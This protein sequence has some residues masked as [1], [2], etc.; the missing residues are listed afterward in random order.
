MG[1]IFDIMYTIPQTVFNIIHQNHLFTWG[2]F[3]SFSNNLEY[4]EWKNT[5]SIDE[6]KRLYYALRYNKFEIL[7]FDWPLCQY[8]KKPLSIDQ[9]S[10]YIK[11]CSPKC[12]SNSDQRKE[13]FAKTCLQK[14]GVTNPSKLTSQRE[15]L[16]N[17]N[18]A[19]RDDVRQK[20]RERIAN[21]SEEDW[22]NILQKRRDTFLQKYGTLQVS[23]TD[24]FQEKS[25]KTCMERYGVEY[26]SQ[27]KEN[28][29]K[30]RALHYDS[31]V[32]TLAKRRISI[33]SSKEEY[34]NQKEVRYRCNVC[35]YEWS[36]NVTAP[37]RIRCIN[38]HG[39]IT[40]Y[41]EQD[42]IDLIKSMY[43]GP[44]YNNIR[45]LLE[46]TQL[47]IDV[48]LPDLQLGLEFNGTYYH[49]TFEGSRVDKYYHQRKALK[50]LQKGIRVYQIFEY[51]WIHNKEKILQDLKALLTCNYK[52]FNTNIID[53]NDFAFLDP[54]KYNYSNIVQVFD[55]QP[56][57][58]KYNNS[59]KLNSTDSIEYKNYRDE[60][61]IIYDCGTVLLK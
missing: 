22:S 12:R 37:D 31:R 17:N 51:D 7:T 52:R 19:K 2:Q 60:F 20:I 16:K 44:V 42:V 50:F 36:T 47:E 59:C 27:R 21:R 41:E 4:V 14:F 40:S 53:L 45:S 48:Y 5:F 33:L 58:I 9:V 8:C 56:S 55:P 46:N 32:V 23:K 43:K 35:G 13:S 25:K 29:A 61:Y 38:R 18:P 1:F 11:F 26:A 28:I 39:K 24:W 10:R 49:R 15:K 54:N 34:C 30:H 3:R 6:F 57:I